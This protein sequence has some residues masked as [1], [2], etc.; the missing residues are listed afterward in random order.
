[1]IGYKRQILNNFNQKNAGF[2]KRMEGVRLPKKSKV[3]R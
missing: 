2:T 3:G 1:M